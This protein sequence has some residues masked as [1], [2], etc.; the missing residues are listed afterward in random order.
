MKCI[1]AVPNL[2]VEHKAFLPGILE[3][4]GLN[5]HPNTHY[6]YLLT[7]LQAHAIIF[8]KNVELSLSMPLS[9]IGGVEV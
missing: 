7:S 3:V 5:L 6:P 1:T 2:A 8:I 9:H 4:A